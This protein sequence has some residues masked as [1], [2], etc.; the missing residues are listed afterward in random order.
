MPKGNR[1]Q[2]HSKDRIPMAKKAK[3]NQTSPAPAPTTSP[4]PAPTVAPAPAPQKATTFRE[5]ALKAWAT[6][7]A[8]GITNQAAKK[9]WETR[10]LR[11]QNATTSPAPAP[12]TSPA[13]APTVATTSP[14]PAPKR[15]RAKG[16]KRT[17]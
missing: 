14:A 15:T 6:M 2:A 10:R 8:N 16:S 17:K 12:T 4:A 3:K 1:A 13:P 7:R 11:A 9:A 5:A